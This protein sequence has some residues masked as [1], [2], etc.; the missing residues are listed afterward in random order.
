[1]NRTLQL[2]V[3]A[4]D[5]TFDISKKNRFFLSRSW[6]LSKPLVGFCMCNPST[7][8]EDQDD[9][10]VYKCQMLARNWEYGGV[11]IVN[12]FS[13]RSTDPAGLYHRLETA[14]IIE[15]N[16]RYIQH[17]ASVCV[18]FVCAWGM[19]AHLN[20]R[21]IMLV[22]RLKPY[23]NKLRH[24]RLCKDGTPMHPLYLPY[25][26]E[27]SFWDPWEKEDAVAEKVQRLRV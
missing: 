18:I 5:A 3:I 20:D 24:L 2:D 14:E 27:P 10:S 13:W 15:E 26:T 19:N 21:H 6:N 16:V 11:N 4:S 8:T 17:V 25:G 1:M 7:A 22:N 9:P 12:A 23:R